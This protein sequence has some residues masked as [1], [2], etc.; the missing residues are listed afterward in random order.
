[1]ADVESCG[2]LGDGEPSRGEL[3]YLSFA[4]GQRGTQEGHSIVDALRA[5]V[6]GQPLL[7][8]ARVAQL[9][10]TGLSNPQIARELHMSVRTVESQV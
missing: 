5:L 4:R 2:D 3:E 10:A 7:P 1:M 8:Q 9:V 6:R